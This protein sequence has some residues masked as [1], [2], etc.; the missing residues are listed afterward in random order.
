MTD[1]PM[2][3]QGPNA[4]VS[5]QVL[6][7]HI[8]EAW[9]SLGHPGDDLLDIITYSDGQF[10]SRAGPGRF[11]V[12]VPHFVRVLQPEELVTLFDTLHHW[13]DD[14]PA[15]HNRDLLVLRA[16]VGILAEKIGPSRRDQQGHQ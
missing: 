3:E 11:G 15:G 16:F 9:V 10:T 1:N 14:P 8:E 6:E 4:P 5:F 13:L 2:T 12:S 7:A